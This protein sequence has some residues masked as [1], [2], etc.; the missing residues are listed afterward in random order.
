MCPPSQYHIRASRVYPEGHS[1]YLSGENGKLL[2]PIDHPHN[3]VFLL[4]SAQGPWFLACVWLYV[5]YLG[6]V[7]RHGLFLTLTESEH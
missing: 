1:S 3:I 7:L 2:G 5:V 6:C 4:C